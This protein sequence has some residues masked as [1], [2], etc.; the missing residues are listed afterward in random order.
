MPRIC[1]VIRRKVVSTSAGDPVASASAS[2]SSGPRQSQSSSVCEKSGIV[3]SP[4]PEG[5]QRHLG[6]LSANASALDAHAA[7]RVQDAPGDPAGTF[8]GEEDIAPRVVLAGQRDV[9]RYPASQFFGPA[10][11]VVEATSA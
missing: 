5:A 3:S 7:V 6:T 2:R 1:P 4:F 8:G 9:Q 10:R 11:C